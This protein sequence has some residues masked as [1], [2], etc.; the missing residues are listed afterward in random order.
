MKAK[1]L[2]PIYAKFCTLFLLLFL[3]MFAQKTKA[4]EIKSLINLPKHKFLQI[5][6]NTDTSC[7]EVSAIKKTKRT[8]NNVL[9]FVPDSKGEK[10][11]YPWPSLSCKSL[12]WHVRAGY[13]QD[14]Y[15]IRLVEVDYKKDT[16]QAVSFLK[17]FKEG[18]KSKNYLQVSMVGAREIYND[19][20]LLLSRKLNDKLTKSILSFAGCVRTDFWSYEGYEGSENNTYCGVV[21]NNNDN[22]VQVKRV[23]FKKGGILKEPTAL[24]ASYSIIDGD[25]FMKLNEKEERLNQEKLTKDQKIK[26]E[27]KEKAKNFRNLFSA[28]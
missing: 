9:G 15:L 14:E 20:T 3:L 13:D 28:D 16:K 26:N 18:E 12:G 1:I 5:V 7:E 27:Q 24:H 4:S 2:P 23:I 19:Y 17:A 25:Y 21:I 11:K 8:I 6:K 10:I 22:L